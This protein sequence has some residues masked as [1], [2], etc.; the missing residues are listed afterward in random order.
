M[1]WLVALAVVSLLAGCQ[2]TDGAGPTSGTTAAPDST[3]TPPSGTTTEPDRT[4]WHNRTGVQCEDPPWQAWAQERG[5]RSGE[6][7]ADG[8]C[9]RDRAKEAT[10]RAYYEEEGMPVDD[11]V[12]YR[13]D[14]AHRAVCGAQ[15][16]GHCWA[17]AP[18]T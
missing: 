16:G 1:R 2:A 6:P 4:V 15:D 9:E 3:G 5:Y 14:R 11:A 8:P 7:G 10:M 17:E 12:A 13:D 18:P